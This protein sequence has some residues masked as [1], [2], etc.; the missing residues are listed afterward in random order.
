MV[1]PIDLQTNLMKLEEI[2]QHQRN[3][4]IQARENDQDRVRETERQKD[5]YITTVTRTERAA[6]EGIVKEREE[7]KRRAKPDAERAADATEGEDT[8]PRH[9]DIVT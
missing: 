2:P 3:V 4:Q 6:Q 5:M 7:E 1:R 8:A 9:I